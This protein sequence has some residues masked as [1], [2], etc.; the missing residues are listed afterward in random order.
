MTNHQTC[1]K[2]N[3]LK[4]IGEVFPYEPETVF[5]SKNG[6]EIDTSKC[7][8]KYSEVSVKDPSLTIF[9]VNEHDAGSYYFTASNAVGSTQS[10][11]IVVG[12][13]V[14]CC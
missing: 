4:L 10:E 1:L 7:G 5:W 8:G 13:S 11:I 14:C 3:F 9:T 6:E 12:K 2:K